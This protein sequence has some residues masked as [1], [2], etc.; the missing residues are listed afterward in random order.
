M[1]ETTVRFASTDRGYCL[2]KSSSII[3]EFLIKED[4]SHRKNMESYMKNNN[5]VLEYSFLPWHNTLPTRQK[6]E[7]NENGH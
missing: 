2:V 5:L 1:K 3:A 7:Y 4:Y 6:Y